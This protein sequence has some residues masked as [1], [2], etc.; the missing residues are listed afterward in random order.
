MALYYSD[1]KEGK[2]AYQNI[3]RALPF[4]PGDPDVLLD[5]ALVHNNSADTEQTLH[6][7][8]RALKQGLS[9]ETVRHAPAFDKLRGDPRFRTLLGH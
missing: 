8:K 3:D 1:I 5:A 2:L 6:W 7:L 4:A 9:P